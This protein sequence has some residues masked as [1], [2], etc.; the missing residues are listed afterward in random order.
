MPEIF[1]KF[2]YNLFQ[3]L[4]MN[5]FIKKLLYISAVL[6]AALFFNGCTKSS[7][8]SVTETKTPTNFKT[9]SYGDSIIYIKNSNTP[10]TINPLVARKGRYTSFPE[11]LIINETTGAI[12]IERNSEGLLKCETGLKYRI[13]FEDEK[14]NKEKT[15]LTISGI[16]Y[17]DHFYHLSQ[18]DSVA[19]P[20]YN[21][22]LQA[23]MPCTGA[24]CTFDEENIA[25][26]AGL[27]VIGTNGQINLA[28]TVR[29]GL[30]GAKPTN[31]KSSKEVVIK[32]R[33]NDQSSKAVNG[34]KVLLYYYNTINEVP[35]YL[36]K[37]VTER[38]EMFA[39]FDANPLDQELASFDAKPRPPCIIIVGQ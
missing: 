10:Y 29:N 30:F 22:V 15:E 38:Q 18:G 26:A 13:T 17:A 20:I 33:L 25:N 14:G 24:G 5:K 28:Q 16:N 4:F 9:L 3:C 35:E 2:G 12:T 39:R 21:N 7:I 8:Q 19:Y 23:N 6:T 36:T 34:L 37:L 1:C 27:S 32:Y 11:G 31:T